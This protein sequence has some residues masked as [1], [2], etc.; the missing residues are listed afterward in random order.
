MTESHPR[1]DEAPRAAPALAVR[2]TGPGEVTIG[3]LTAGGCALLLF[4]NEDCP[5]SAMAMRRLGPLCRA[6]QEAGLAAVAV[7]EDPLEV[8]VRVARRLGWA[9]Q[10]AAEDPPY[11]TS[12]AYQLVSVPTAVL[13][14]RA[15][16]IARSVTGWDHRAL[17]ALIGQAEALLGAELAIPEATEPL[18]KPG[19][20]SK[21]AIDPELAAAMS[22]P[23]GTDDIEEMFERGWTDGL[24]VVPPTPERVEAMLGAADGSS[25]LGL[26]PPAMGE[27]TLERVAACAVLAGCRP[28]YFPVVVAAARAALDPAFNLHG[29]AV[30]TQPAGQL[31]VVNG[32]ARE[33]IGLNSGMGALGPGCRANLTV[34]RALRLLVTL[35]GGAMPGRLDRATLGHMGKIGFCIAEDEEVSPWEPLHVERGFQPGQSV[36]TVIGSDAPL[37]ISDHRSRTP[38]DLAWVL[39]WAAASAWSTNWWPLEEPS[40]FVICPEHAEM[41]RAAGWTKQRLRQFM[42]EAVRRPAREL[43]RGETTPAVHAADPAAQ[44]PK[45]AAPEAIVLV[46]AGAEAGRYSAV[47]GPCT[48]MG[49]QIVSREV[50]PRVG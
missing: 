40:V 35:T 37:S 29:Q 44:I 1:R 46:V 9:G 10:V 2:G 27:A 17:A 14:D 45:W 18:L 4:V 41:F 23:A 13:V 43:R 24:P 48:G 25:S 3:G 36:V 16:T 11:E 34:G 33:A 42:F 39:G 26:V 28:A 7:F 47:L 50:E 5:T 30:T 19:C 8:A 49:S 15:G 22:A 12:R 38:E 20:S 6:W 32:P 31:V 21:A